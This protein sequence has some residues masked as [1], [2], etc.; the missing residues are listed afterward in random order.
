LHAIK[1]NCIFLP[2]TCAKMLFSTISAT[3]FGALVS[4]AVPTSLHTTPSGQNCPKKDLWS[5]SAAALNSTNGC[6]VENKSGLIMLAHFW[7]T[8][9]G[10]FYDYTIHGTWSDKCCSSSTYLSHKKK[11]V[12]FAD[13][14]FLLFFVSLSRRFV[15]TIL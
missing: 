12:L 5:C 7:D 4:A 13:H 10:S 2:A 14:R 11:V 3:V 15:G 6:C 1:L 8:H 9:S